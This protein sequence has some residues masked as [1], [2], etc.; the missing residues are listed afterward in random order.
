MRSPEIR[1]TFLD[2]FSARGHRVVPSSTLVPSDP[3]LLLTGAGMDQFKPYFLGRAEPGHPRAASVQKCA[4]TSDIGNVGRTARHSTFFEMLGN[5][6]FGDYFKEEAVGWA[7]E[8]LTEGFGLEPERLWATVHL[9]D[10]EAERLWLRLGVPASRIQRLGMADNYWSMG[11]PGPCGPSSELHYDRGPAFGREGGPA[12]DGERYLE[13]W[14][15]VFMQNVRGEGPA[16]EGY[17]IVG[18]LPARSID[19]GLGL[20]RLAAILQGVDTL[21]ETDLVGPVLRLVQE[22]AG[23]EYPGRDGSEASRSFLVAAEHARTIAF[24]VADGVLPSQDGR[25]HVLRRLMRGAVRHARLLGIDGPV[26]PALTA[27][28]V[29]TLAPAWPELERGRELIRQV[30]E[31][32]EEGFDRALR[33]GSR[34]LDSAIAKARSAGSPVLPG[35]TA[36]DLLNIHGFPVDL[37]VDAARAAGLA[38]DEDAFA[39]LLDEQ[40]RRAHRDGQGRKGG[41][42]ARRELYGRVA[43]R[44]G[45]TAFT[46]YDAT[47]GT[48][49]VVALLDGAGLTGHASE[50]GEIEVVLDR[51]PFYAE[52]GGQVGDTGTL[53]TDSAVLEVVDTRLGV[54]GLHVHTARVTEGEVRTGQEAEAA[55]DGRRRAAVARSHSATHVLHAMLRRFLGE[56]AA[57][58]GSR[59]EPGRLRF[60]FAHFA[61]V[62]VEAVQA[63]VN[64]YLLD[65]PDVRVWEADRDEAVAAGA[66]AM[67][68]EKYGDRVRVVDI[69]DASRELCVGTHVG[70]GT[71]AGPLRIVGDTSVGTGLRR[72]EALTGA[73]ALRHHDREH[74]LL[75]ELA[76]LLKVPADQAPARLR[77][78][79]EVLAATRRELDALR[80]AERAALTSRLADRAERLPDGSWL[81][82]E[83]VPDDVTDGDLRPLALDVLALRPGTVVLGTRAGGRATLVA[84]LSDGRGPAREVLAEAAAEVGGGAG[85]KGSVAHAGG[86][87]PE[88]LERAVARAARTARALIS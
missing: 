19:T 65:D 38:V 44:H 15:L 37:T 70:H 74:A 14:N 23:R 34:V 39:T 77:Q 31:A 16:K 62:D 47:S 5:F 82:A 32:E 83:V 54:D 9:D 73:D 57:Q 13:V 12:V 2:F 66:V 11:V 27:R 24:L 86:R 60:D 59:V 1:Q 10:E 56:H 55:V 79:L 4:R 29:E 85:G 81:V 41:A 58:R 51:S 71:Q 46:G 84:A 69:G 45:T 61:G 30:T 87:R 3:T 35:R 25:G 21:C 75:A 50:G 64:D 7:W 72:I 80:A 22:M 52:S 36:F 40:R 6:S 18:E 78:R 17:P 42:V 76:A 49:R 53:R 68:G 88:H 48:G 33:Q 20:D 67:F 63:L 26:L 28:V 43:A 8:L